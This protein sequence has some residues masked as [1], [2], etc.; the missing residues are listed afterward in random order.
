MPDPLGRPVEDRPDPLVD[1]Q[2][3]DLGREDVVEAVEDQAGEA[4]GLGVDDPVGVGRLVELE[5]VAAEGDGLV[6]PTFPEARTGGL[7]AGG[8]QPQVDLRSGVPEPEADRQ[9]V[10]VDDAD[11]VAVARSDRADRVR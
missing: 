9:A 7:D 4:V 6:E 8:E 1:P 10:A 5:E 3:E 2:A 11:H